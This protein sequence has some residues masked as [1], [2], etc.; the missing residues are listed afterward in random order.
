MRLRKATGR[1]EVLTKTVL[2]ASLY[3]YAVGVL[4]SPLGIVGDGGDFYFSFPLL[5]FASS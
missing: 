4:S 2:D 5:L 3:T 1:P